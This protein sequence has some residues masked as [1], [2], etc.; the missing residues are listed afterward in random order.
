MIGQDNNSLGALLHDVAHLLR[1]TIDREVAPY[2]LTRAKWLALSVL[3]RKEGL[4]QTELAAQLELGDAT[5]GRL[6]ERLEG[7]GFIERRPDVVDARVKRLFI[8][9]AAR[10]EL[11]ELE[12]VAEDMRA[13]ALRGLTK[14]DQ[15]LLVKFL[16]TIKT[17][18]SAACQTLV[19]VVAGV[20]HSHFQ[21]AAFI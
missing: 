5:V 6:V 4:T 9:K 21:S 15:R 1:V 17:N 18:L 19:F 2:N 16:T 20:V 8:R 3:K 7:R 13:V 11:L 12:N 10:P 14:A